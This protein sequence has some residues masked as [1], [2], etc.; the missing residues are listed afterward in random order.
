MGVGLGVGM[1]V[2]MG[3]GMGRWEA[4]GSDSCIWRGPQEF[5]GWEVGGRR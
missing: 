4:V 2:R 3:V 1:G 5:L